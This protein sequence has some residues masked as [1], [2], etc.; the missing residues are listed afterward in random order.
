MQPNT[1]IGELRKTLLLAFPIASGHL[2][3]MALGFADTLMIGR[4]GVLPL[5]ASAFAHTIAHFALIIG[6]GLLTSVSVLAA[7][8]HGAGA[9][10]EAAEVLRR[11]LAIAGGAGTLM[12]LGLWAAFP[13]LAFLGQPPEVV[14]ECKPY[15]WLLALSMPFALSAICFRNYAEAQDAPWPAFWAGLASVA[16][17]IFLNWVL[18][19]GNLGMPALGLTGAGV[20]TLVSRIVNLLLLVAW[21]R[22]DRRFVARWPARWLAP[23]PLAP[24][25]A[26]L[27]LGFPVAMQLLMEVGAFGVATLL[28][29]WLGIVELA[30]HQ[31]ALT[32]AATTFMVPLGISLAVAIRVGH[33]IGAGELPRARRIGFG[34]I[35]FGIL[36]SG[37]FAAGF[38]L[39]NTPLAGIFNKDPDTVALAARL[40]VVAG[41]FQLF[42]AAQVLSIGAL[43]GCKDVRLPTWIVFAA[44][45]LAAIPAGAAL[46]FGLGFGAIGLWIGLALGLALAAAGLAARFALVTRGAGALPPQA[47]W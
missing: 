32:C 22:R 46:A 36:L 28:M 25:A 31:I 41:L 20:A 30:A 19:Y 33:V 9:R 17:N 14:T 39:F 8:A 4:V 40:I 42:D 24:L 21:M 5:A 38:I 3:Q 29:G 7:H 2:S 47:G 26:M 16:L 12:F 23:L 44:Y 1:H 45:W 13:A 37:L 15:L 34:A 18:I 11:G 43:R 35:G 6:I 10:R 27:R